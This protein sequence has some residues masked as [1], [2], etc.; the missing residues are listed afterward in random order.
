MISL[1]S[2]SECCGC[3][4]CSNICPRSCIEMCSDET[5]FLYPE[6]NYSL[7]EECGLC[8]KVC[9]SLN[10]LHSVDTP[11]SA[12]V[13]QH[14]DNAIRY[15][16]TSGGAFTGIAEKT[17]DE[18]G[19]VFGASFNDN[20]H[21]Y[22]SYSETSIGLGRFRSSKYVQSKIGKTF[23]EAKD[24]LDEGRPVCFS[25]SPC[26]V[27]GLKS[28]LRKDYDN[29][30]TVDFLCRAV[31][32]PL[33]YDKYLDFQKKKLG[34][35]KNIRFRDKAFGYSFSTLSIEADNNKNRRKYHKGVESDVWLRAFFSRVC[36]R[37][38]CANCEF[39]GKYHQSDFTIWDCINV[40]EY[41]PD[42]DD[43]LGTTRVM[44]RG[45]KANKYFNEI[46]S[47]FK[48]VEISP[49]DIYDKNKK[50]PLSF[51]KID[52]YNFYKDAQVMESVQF[53]EKYFPNTSKIKAMY[54]ARL[55]THKLKIYNFL[56]KQIWEKVKRR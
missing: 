35:I 30:I 11:R 4:A 37:P 21:I 16:S 1:C 39:Q 34:K 17:I 24:F 38:C 54:L 2:K 42:L 22:H 28:F 6:I 10:K 49:A 8:T 46:K 19:V 14:K 32:S 40:S 51:S 48:F 20:F 18:G 56:K 33:I 52:K 44:V 50:R 55:I 29:L 45:L 27:A 43:N 47:V 5:G 13:V 3:G 12:Y 9:P 53:F 25:G 31:P 15:Q 26:Q 7:C 41:A 23:T 36:D